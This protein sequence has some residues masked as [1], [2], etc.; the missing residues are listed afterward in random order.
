MNVVSARSFPCRHLRVLALSLCSL[1]AAPLAHAQSRSEG[2]AASGFGGPSSVQSQLKA[3]SGP[4]TP[5]NSNR[6]GSSSG[7]TFGGD[8]NIMGQS[9]SDGPGETDAFGGVARLYG[10]WTFLGR[11]TPDTGALHFKIES[12]HRLGTAIPPQS[13]GPAL[14]YAGLTSVGFSDAGQLL[15]NF[16]WQQSFNNNKIAFVAGIVDTTD[17]LDVYS[18]ISP[19]TGFSNFAF[20]TNPTIPA[21]SQGLGAAI[22]WRFADNYYVMAGLADANGQ[23]DDPVGSIKNLFDTGETFKHVEFGWYETYENRFSDNF[24]LSAWQIDARSAAGVD[25]GWGVAV[26]GSRTLAE[27]WTPFFRAGY[28]DGGGGPVDR[29]VSV[30]TGYTLFGGR[31]QLGLGLNWGRAPQG[32]TVRQPRDQY[33]AEVFYRYQPHKNVQIT[34]DLQYIVNPAFAP[35][36]GRM[37]VVGLRI[38]LAF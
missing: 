9:A 4:K 17:Y 18:L 29:S 19:W 22:R 35:G 6:T 14:G 8:I 25:S 28:A 16:F 3:D 32:T 7:L 13:L 38:R 33:T 1:S 26:S 36:I 27:R 2:D 11:G 5:D 34:P 12:R 31:D 23:P 20:W 30:G 37:W 24:H 15:T 21:P 10:T